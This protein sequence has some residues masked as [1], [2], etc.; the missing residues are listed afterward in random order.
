[1]R[2]YYFAGQTFKLVRVKNGGQYAGPC[3]FDG[4]GNDRFIIE[5]D[6]GTWM[7]RECTSTCQHGRHSSRGSFRYGKL[8]EVTGENERWKFPPRKAVKVVPVQNNDYLDVAMVFQKQLKTEQRAYLLSRGLNTETIDRFRLGNYNER[9]V[10]IPRL[11]HDEGNVLRCGAI[12]YRTLPRY[13]RD[14]IPKYRGFRHHSTVGIFNADALGDDPELLVIGNSLFDVML[15]DQLGFAV[16]GSFAGEAS[17]P[18]EWSPLIKA[19]VIVNLQDNDPVNKNTGN[20]PGEQYALSRAVK[21]AQCPNVTHVIT[22]GP[23]DNIRD[24]G[25]MQERGLDIAVWLSKLVEGRE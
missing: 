1:M 2:E 15:I 16:I 4:Q 7:C 18:E 19:R 23:P 12:K 10:T 9:G 14:G 6:T 5:P 11:Y 24:V 20:S 17:W 3:P 22:T 8:S 13:C 25:N 21:L